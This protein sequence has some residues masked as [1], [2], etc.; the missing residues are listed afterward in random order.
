MSGAGLGYRKHP[1]KADVSYPVRVLTT[2]YQNTTGR[3][4]L[5]IVSATMNKA[6]GEDCFMNA[7]IEDVTPPTDTVARAG[8][9]VGSA[10]QVITQT[11]SFFVPNGYYYRISDFSTGASTITIIEWTEVTL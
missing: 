9:Y 5:V 3:P 10:V 2:I 4:I 6:A 7:L 1:V 8:L 11:L